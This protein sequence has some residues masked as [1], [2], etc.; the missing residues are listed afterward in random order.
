M[1]CRYVA[2][3]VGDDK[4]SEPSTAGEA[5]TSLSWFAPPNVSCSSST[6]DASEMPACRKRA[7]NPVKPMMS[8]GGLAY[9]GYCA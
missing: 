4:C 7:M 2:A 9:D 8:V 3:R 6:E 5:T 1:E